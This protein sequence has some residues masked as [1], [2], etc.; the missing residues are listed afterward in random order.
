[1]RQ[2]YG[3]TAVEY[4]PRVSILDQAKTDPRAA[5]RLAI[6]IVFVQTLFGAAAQILMKGGT[7]VQ[8][9]DGVI[10]MFI[11]IFTTPQLFIGYALCGVSTLLL[12]AALRYGELSVLYP[13]IAMTYVW[14]TMLSVFIHSESLRLLKL[15]GLASIV[16]GVAVLGMSR[17]SRQ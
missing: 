5:R 7:Q 12:I 2:D 17:T 11:G 10:D 16:L 14:V 13:V 6:G 1:M 3:L 4:N 15:A 9:S 8:P